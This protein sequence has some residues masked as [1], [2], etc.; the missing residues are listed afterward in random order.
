MPATATTAPGRW[1]TGD[2]KF[3][4]PWSYSGL[5]VVSL[6]CG[7]AADGLPVAVQLVGRPFAEASLLSAAAWCEECLKFPSAAFGRNQR[8]VL[9]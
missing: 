7:L 5:P 1:T 8:G 3:N 9:G 4:S 6:P 2:P